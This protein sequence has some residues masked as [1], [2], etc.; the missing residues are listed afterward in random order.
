MEIMKK[1]AIFLAFA[2]LVLLS[3]NLAAQSR[4]QLFREAQDLYRSGSYGQAAALFD[5]LEDPLSKA[6]SILCASK[7]NSTNHDERM[8]RYIDKEASSVLDSRIH[9]T[10]AGNLFDEGNYEAAV[11][12]FSQVDLALLPEAEQSE[13]IFK[14]AYSFFSLGKYNAAIKDFVQ[15]QS[16]PYSSYTAPSCF[17]LAYMAYSIQDFEIAELWFKKAVVDERFKSLAEYYIM[18]CRFMS[19]DYDFVLKNAPAMLDTLPAERQGRMA[20]I[21]SES[22]LVRGQSDKALQYLNKESKPDNRTDFFH[23]GSVLYAVED[24]KGAIENFS[25]MESRTD[26]IGQVASYQLGYSYIQTGNKVSAAAAFKE[27]SQLSFDSVIQEDAAFNY[28][29]LSFDLNGDTTPFSEYISKYS[30]DKRGEQIYN[31]MAIGALNKRDYTA[32]IENYSKI[33]ELDDSQK[34]NYIKANYLRAGQLIS[35]GAWSSAIPYLKAAGFYYPKTNRFNQLSRYWLAEANYNSGNFAEAGR[36]WEELYNTSALRG[37]QESAL[38][39]YNIGYAFYSDKKYPQAARWFDLYAASKDEFNREDALLRRADCDFAMHSYREAI[40]YYQRVLDEFGEPDKLYP[41][42]QQA[43]AYGLSG[44][45]K[46]KINV[47]LAVK[48]ASPDAPL[49]PEAM[50][51][52]GRA[53]MEDGKYQNAAAIFEQL[54]V[55]TSDKTFAARALIGKGMAYR[56]IKAYDTALQQYK[57]VV[58]LVPG[59]EYAEE[60]ML[61]I[62][63]IY[64]TTGT[65]EKY[66]EYIESSGL[67]IGKSASEK[68]AVYFN[69]AEQIYL[70]GNYKSAV[71]YLR[72]YISDYPAGARRGDAAFYLADSY[73]RLGEK[74]KA[75]ACYEDAGKYLSKG[76]FA[77]SAALGHAVLSYELEHFDDALKA[78]TKLFEIAQ[79]SENKAI[80]RLGM[81]RSAYSAKNWAQAI[82]AAD[83]I[84]SSTDP[85]AQ[86][87]EAQFIKAN[88]LLAQSKRKE[89]FSIFAKLAVLTTT[90]EGAESAYMV[91]QDHFDQ[92][93]YDKVESSVYSYAGKFGLQTYWLARCY[94][95]LADTFTAKGN[96]VQAKATLESIRDGYIPSGETDDIMTLVNE[97]LEKLQ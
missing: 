72:K 59:S 2:T 83:K 51:E 35:G 36:I 78:Y 19:D 69:T 55:S 68:E 90:D 57:Q 30:T 39:T 21:I 4:A 60:A 38:L 94:I 79:M 12:E 84:E 77:E 64:Q 86:K 48:K 81:L 17:Y 27:A 80:A 66:I 91:V 23:A 29:K 32:A 85:E 5:K 58:S 53:Y 88:S 15:L 45:N 43:L 26:S 46:T 97:R 92:G 24:Y 22:Y 49:Y 74:E 44:Q 34:G 37:M 40:K 61:A 76:S 63:S 31:Y 82:E 73:S 62:N 47:L 56:N 1:S 28:A 54:R 52:L 16:R 33:E 20:R 3:P 25:R 13:C 96:N 89:A 87:R 70:A 7:L 71:N 42:Y 41:V 9:M 65:P 8:S 93:N 18:E 6:Y 95:V 50:Y 14:K 11:M 10:M 67:N 75:C